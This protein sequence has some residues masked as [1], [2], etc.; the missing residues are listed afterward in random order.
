[1][2][3]R[4]VK[5]FYSG[6]GGIRYVAQRRCAHELRS[7]TVLRAAVLRK[8]RRIGD[9]AGVFEARQ[10]LFHSSHVGM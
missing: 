1:M 6:N 8:V 9:G 10:W 7:R 5:Q 2:T 3:Q 4:A